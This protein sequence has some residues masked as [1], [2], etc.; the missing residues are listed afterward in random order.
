MVLL[1]P[2]ADLFRPLPLDAGIPKVGFRAFAVPEENE[3]QSGKQ[4]VDSKFVLH[5]RIFR[6]ERQVFANGTVDSGICGPK[7]GSAALCL[8]IAVQGRNRTAVKV[9][10]SDFPWTGSGQMGVGP[11]AIPKKHVS[12]PDF[13]AESVG[14]DEPGSFLDEKK[15]KGLQFFAAAFET[16]WHFL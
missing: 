3:Q 15:E 16:R 7:D 12:G 5:A 11:A 9:H 10:P 1:D 14:F 6:Q 8:K 13:A 2:Q 4:F